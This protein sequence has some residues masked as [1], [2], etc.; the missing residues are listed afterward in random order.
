MKHRIFLLL[1]LLVTASFANAQFKQIAQGPLFEEPEK[2]EAI[3]LQLKNGNTVFVHATPKDGLNFRVYN[4]AHQETVIKNIKPMAGNVELNTVHTIFEIN[5]DIVLMLGGTVDKISV[6]YRYILNGNTLDQKLVEKIGDL[7]TT[8]F[9]SYRLAYGD[10]P[11]PHFSVRKDPYSDNYA[12]LIMNSFEP[13]K[14]KRI[15]VIG[16]GADNKENKRGFYPATQEEY[17]YFKYVD[18]TVIGSDKVSVLISGYNT[19][20]SNTDR[21]ALIVANLDKGSTSLNFKELS[22]ASN[23][24]IDFAVIRYDA[25]IKSLVVIALTKE[26]PRDAGYTPVMAFVNPAD[27]K[28][29]RN[30]VISPSENIDQYSKKGFTG[31]P[32]NIVINDDGSITVI[33]EE[34][35]EVTAYGQYGSSTTT[36]I[37]NLAIVSYSKTGEMG[38]EYLV[39]KSHAY[40]NRYL[41]PLYKANS[42][43]YTMALDQGNQFKSFAY[44]DGKTKSYVLFNDTERN[45]DRQEEGKLVTVKGVSDCD[46]FYYTLIGK[47]IIPK[48]DYVFGNPASKSDHNLAIFSISDYNREKNIYVTLE[49]S[50]ENG[51]KGVRVVWLQP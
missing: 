10:V 25:P 11:A 13:E 26:K 43:N 20:H 1:F 14:G 42:A 45:N 9:Q 35:Q 21:T 48:R 22:F 31:L 8:S 2:G 40:N 51:K 28:L 36:T 44:L 23:L 49:L 46:A 27:N 6:L 16:Y 19:S 15:E 5:G 17:K 37:G 34:M 18:M 30:S 32:Q 3:I 41:V 7:K 39:R 4:P 29:G 47:D 12:V 38:T 24:F 33:F 50:K